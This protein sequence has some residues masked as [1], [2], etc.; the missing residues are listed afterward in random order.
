MVSTGVEF[1]R[2]LVFQLLQN[3][4]LHNFQRCLSIDEV[5]VEQLLEGYQRVVGLFFK[6]PVTVACQIVVKVGRAFLPQG[7]DSTAPDFFVVCQGLTA[8]FQLTGNTFGF[9]NKQHHDV[10]GG[11]FEVHQFG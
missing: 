2:A 7:T 11:L 5:I 3:V 9:V 6:D 8:T 1:Q 4:F 10:K